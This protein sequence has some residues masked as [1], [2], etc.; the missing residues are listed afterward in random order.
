MGSQDTVVDDTF[1]KEYQGDTIHQSSGPADLAVTNEYSS[2][3]SEVEQ[4]KE[5][6]P[7]KNEETASH[8]A[9]H[10][11][12]ENETEIQ[13]LLDDLD[14]LREQQKHLSI[15]E[16]GVLSRLQEALRYK[17]KTTQSSLPKSHKIHRWADSVDAYSSGDDT[18]R[19]S[20]RARKSSDL[21]DENSAM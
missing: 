3:E 6:E 5:S 14:D 2:G 8:N 10:Q 12:E 1:N 9:R 17:G 7:Y 4:L 21:E 16:D 19:L 15:Q 20:K 18:H 13:R 11:P